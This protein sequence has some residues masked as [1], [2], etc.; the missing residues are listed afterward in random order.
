MR[1][2]RRQDEEEREHH[3]G[4]SEMEMQDVRG[5]HD[6]QDRQGSE[7]AQ[8]VPEVAHGQRD[9]SGAALLQGDLR[10]ACREVLGAVA[11]ARAYRRGAR[12]PLRRWHLHFKGACRAYR[13]HEGACRRMAPRRERM[14]GLLG[15][16]HA[17]GRASCHGRHGWRD[18]LQEGR[19]RHLARCARAALPRACEAPGCE[20]DDHEPEAR[21]RSRTAK[22]REEASED[23]GRGCGGDMDGGL[24]RVVLEVGAVPAGVHLEGR[25]Q[26]VRPRAPEERTAFPERAR[27]GR[28]DVHLHR[29]AE[30]VRGRL[31][32]DQQRHRG[33]G[34]LADPPHAPE[35]SRT[36]D[37][38]PRQGG[39][40]VVLPAFGVQGERSRDAQDDEDRR[41][42][43]RVVRI[44]FQEEDQR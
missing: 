17:Q 26:A 39:I 9:A 18:R 29:D 40:L 16:A 8:S 43:R 23:E 35:P 42:S 24:R 33:R 22:P 32:L 4:C 15:G 21:L 3:I 12:H 30:G 14:L 28:H 1:C 5:E 31:G 10:A 34:Q 13:L 11:P 27:Q 38:A 7:A 19:A 44:G 25:S 36:D 37:A 41:G 2:L 20:E 6:A